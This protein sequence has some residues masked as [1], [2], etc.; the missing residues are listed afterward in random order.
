MIE[1]TWAAIA[2]YTLWGLIATA[3]IFRLLAKMPTDTAAPQRKESRI[4]SRNYS[5]TP[6]PVERKR[7][8]FEWLSELEVN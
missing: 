8:G 7:S 6:A 3:A 5:Y 2:V 4:V 1:P